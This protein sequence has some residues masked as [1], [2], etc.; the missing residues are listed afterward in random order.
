M[1]LN[2]LQSVRPYVLDCVRAGVPVMIHGRRGTGKSDL[3]RSIARELF[4]GRMIDFRASTV[5]PTDIGGLPAIDLAAGKARYLPSE[6]LPDAAR[7]GLDGLLLCDELNRAPRM[8]QNALLGLI[9]DGYV[10]AYRK[11]AGWAIMA[12]GNLASE[13]AFLEP[14]DPALKARLAH[15]YVQ[16][17]LLEVLEYGEKAGWSPA[18]LAFLRHAPECLYSDAD[19]DEH[20]DANPR[21]WDQLSRILKT[22]P[23]DR[24]NGHAAGKIGRKVAE[25][26]AGFMAIWGALPPLPAIIAD[27]YFAP[28]PAPDQAGLLYALQSALARAADQSNFAAVVAYLARLP[29]EFAIA[30]VV[31]AVRR[32]PSLK[33][34]AGFITWAVA[35]QD[36]TI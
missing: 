1:Q 3:A 22:A 33:S 14:M 13:K 25:R 16:A 20:A 35:N 18:V 7:D 36:V 5:E 4:D 2:S 29:R 31:A 19:K 26:F 21:S 24:W 10:G 32:D 6:L 11:P 27:P 12:A 23:R 8:T 30:G 28:V 9:L 34:T 17:D 15:F